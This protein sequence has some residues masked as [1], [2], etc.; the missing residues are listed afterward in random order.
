MNEQYK[1]LLI[2]DCTHIMDNVT[3]RPEDNNKR[4]VFQVIHLCDEVNIYTFDNYMERSA[5]IA[6]SITTTDHARQIWKERKSKGW[7]HC[8]LTYSATMKYGK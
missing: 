3:G 1:S 2:Q 5:D 7:K 4:M 6:P 8:A